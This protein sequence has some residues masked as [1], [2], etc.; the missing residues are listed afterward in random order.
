MNETEEESVVLLISTWGKSDK[1]TKSQHTR[2][3]GLH[4]STDNNS[5]VYNVVYK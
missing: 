4:F 5:D 1:S 3:S 2:R